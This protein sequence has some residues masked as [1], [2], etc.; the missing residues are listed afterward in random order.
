MTDELKHRLDA[1]LPSGRVPFALDTDEAVRLGRRSRKH[2]RLLAGGGSVLSAV[3]VVALVVGLL[4]PGGSPSESDDAADDPATTDTDFPELDPDLVYSWAGPA[5]TDEPPKAESALSEAF[6]KHIDTAF[7]DAQLYGFLDGEPI[8]DTDR[9][10][11]G[12]FYREEQSLMAEP[13]G[14]DPESIPDYIGFDRQT[15][16][17]LQWDHSP[18]GPGGAYGSVTIKFDQEAEGPDDIDVTVFPP[19]GFKKDSGDAYDLAACS[20]DMHQNDRES[21]VAEPA[22]GPNGEE[23]REVT[24]KVRERG[25]SSTVAA[26]AVVLY[27]EDGSAV[28]VTDQVQMAHQP[29]SGPQLTL[30][31]LQGIAAAIAPVSVE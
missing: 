8:A 11:T 6:W 19:G 23:L 17:L 12:F 15:H 7:P 31:E 22:T 1:E 30:K 16:S 3:A 2:R 20:T 10:K 28:L 26:H 18:D 27:R 5:Y 25:E 14:D 13:I 24:M 21:C 9:V 29:G 4:A